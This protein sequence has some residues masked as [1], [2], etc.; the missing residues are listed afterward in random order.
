MP[1]I[2]APPVFRPSSDADLA[3]YYALR[4]RRLRQPWGQGPDA[5]DAAEE[6]GSDHLAIRSPQTGEMIACGRL[7][8]LGSGLA[9][10][11]SMA[12]AEGHQ[13]QGLGRRILQSLE[14]LARGRGVTRLR[15]HAR[16]SALGFYT[17]SG[18]ADVGPGTLLFDAIPHRW[19][20]RSLDCH[21]FA[22]FGLRRRPA[23]RGDGAAV[24]DLVFRVLGDYGLAPEPDG[25]D[26]DLE[27]LQAYYREGFFDLLHDEQGLLR[28]TVA[29]RRLSADRGEL[30]RMYLDPSCRGLG[31][32]R[33]CLGHALAW[34]RS[35][36]I[37]ELELETATAL[38]EARAL[39]RW[40]GFQPMDGSNEARRC[41][42][43]MILR[44]F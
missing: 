12:V 37:V 8:P 11:R 20:E 25:I 21:D 33:A 19:L 29:V 7:V 43:R 23:T 35:Q 17:R 5:P 42:L 36:G 38:R 2:Q 24:A 44:D 14:A 13:G 9:Q 22:G 10:I 41:D 18:Y 34:A 1:I 6:A 4:W 30:R 15:I 39:Y 26:R 40:A 32:G 16:D 28:A 27:D 3:D 31:L